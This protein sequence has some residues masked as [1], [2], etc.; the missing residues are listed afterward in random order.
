MD[1]RSSERRPSNDS[2]AIGAAAPTRA[3]ILATS[4]FALSFAALGPGGR[5]GKGLNAAS[6]GNASSARI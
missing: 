1:D 5:A 2:A 4:S 6:G 3:L